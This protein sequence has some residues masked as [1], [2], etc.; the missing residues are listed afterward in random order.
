MRR[1]QHL[2]ADPIARSR[3]QSARGRCWL[4]GPR[5]TQS[6][7]WVPPP[8]PA[9]F[10]GFLPGG[11]PPPSGVSAQVYLAFFCRPG[12][13]SGC[14]SRSSVSQAIILLT[15]SVVVQ[16]TGEYPSRSLEQFP[17]HW[18]NQSLAAYVISASFGWVPCALSTVPGCLGYSTRSLRGCFLHSPARFVGCP[19]GTQHP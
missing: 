15:V 5:R 11:G 3:P 8:T 16:G 18:L 19:S 10:C 7:F 17:T 13:L 12:H 14:P 4:K 2:R 9:S 6:C 1:R